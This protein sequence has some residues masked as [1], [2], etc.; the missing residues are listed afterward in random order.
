MSKK[1]SGSLGSSSFAR[2]QFKKA[3][4]TIIATGFLRKSDQNYF[5]KVGGW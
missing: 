3:G 5:R 2:Q 4:G 1:N